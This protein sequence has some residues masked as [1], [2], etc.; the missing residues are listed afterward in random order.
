M[1]KASVFISQ[2]VSSSCYTTRSRDKPGLAVTVSVTWWSDMACDAVF[3]SHTK[4]TANANDY[5]V[6]LIKP[7]MRYI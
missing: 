5:T 6:L 3:Y 2:S 4:A 7:F 1:K